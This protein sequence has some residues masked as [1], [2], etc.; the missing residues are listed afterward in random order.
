MENH[1]RFKAEMTWSQFRNRTLA[2][3]TTKC[4]YFLRFKHIKSHHGGS[5]KEKKEERIKRTVGE[6]DKI[7][8]GRLPR[9]LVSRTHLR[10]ELSHPSFISF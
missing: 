10:L 1:T 7:R 8:E 9:N 3:G 4:L 2:L 6:M 5:L